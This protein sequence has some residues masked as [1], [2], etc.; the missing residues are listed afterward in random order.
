MDKELFIKYL[1]AKNL[2][3]TSVDCYVELVNRFFRHTKKEAIQVTKPDILNYLNYLKNSRKQQNITR[4]NSLIALNHYFTY[5]FENEQIAKNPCLFIKIRGT[6]RKMLY[7]IY[8]LEELEQL[9]DAYYQLFVRSFDDSYMPK[10]NRERSALSKERNAL[11][12]S[13]L[14]Y[15]GAVASEID[16]IEL[17]DLDLIK[18]TIRIRGSKRHNERILPLK[19][20][21]MGLF[22]NYLQKTRPQLLEYHTKE[23]NKLFL[24][25]PEFS[26]KRTENDSLMDIF[27]RLGKQLKTIDKQFFNFKQLRASV[28]TNWLKT[29]GL[30]KTQYLAGHKWISSTEAYLPNNLDDL[31]EDINK[32]HPF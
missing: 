8:S 16:K 2:A 32:L 12:V 15:Q 1:E 9:Y 30:R 14:V 24:A 6:R 26:K 23:S 22:I 3:K 7:K 27:K 20:A 13:I 5:L 21:Q 28:I 19:A 10:R 25:L 17:T 29:Q 18:A 31:T 11:I 4:R